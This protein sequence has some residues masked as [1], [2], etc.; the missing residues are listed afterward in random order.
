MFVPFKPLLALYWYIPSAT[1]ISTTT[2]TAHAVQK[3]SEETTALFYAGKK[4]GEPPRKL[5]PWLFERPNY[6]RSGYL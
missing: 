3:V 1:M 4:Q 5:T 2:S 6:L